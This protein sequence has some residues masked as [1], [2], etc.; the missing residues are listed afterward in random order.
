[1][2]DNRNSQPIPPDPFKGLP[3]CSKNADGTISFQSDESR[4][5]CGDRVGEFCSKCGVPGTPDILT[6]DHVYHNQQ[7][8]SRLR[9][10]NNGLETTVLVPDRGAPVDFDHL[11]Q[12]AKL[13]PREIEIAQYIRQ[14]L[15]NSDMMERLV[16][17]ESTLK[18]HLNNIYRKVPNLKTFR[19]QLR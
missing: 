4:H 11:V 15:T 6:T 17:S 13:S 18:T 19:S 1:M 2:T 9:V 12:S 7:V 14:N 3:V 10:N 8:F 5:I 16:V